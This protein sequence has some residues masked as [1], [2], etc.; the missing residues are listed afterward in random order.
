MHLDQPQPAFAAVDHDDAFDVPTCSYADRDTIAQRRLLD[1][2]A[3]V[4]V[5]EVPRA[6][7]LV[8][9][10]T[11]D[12]P[13]A[14]M[15]DGEQRLVDL[16]RGALERLLDAGVDDRA[17]RAALADLMSPARTVHVHVRDRDG[18]V[19]GAVALFAPDPELPIER[20]RP[21]LRRAAA[22]LSGWLGA[23]VDATPA[24]AL[25]E[26]IPYPALVYEAG[27]VVMANHA[28]ARLCGYGDPGRLIGRGVC[29]MLDGLPPIPFALGEGHLRCRATSRRVR[30]RELSLVVGGRRHAALVLTSVDGG[31]LARASI[32]ASVARVTGELAAVIHACA[33]L[34][35]EVPARAMIAG[36]AAELDGLVRMALLDVATALDDRAAGNHIVVRAYDDGAATI[37]EIVASGRIA[38]G[39]RFG[40]HLG[41]TLCARHAAALDATVAVDATHAQ[42]RS[43]RLS[44]PTVAS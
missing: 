10:R 27:V 35:V 22:A 28:L 17:A 1:G 43:V 21:A 7:A 32:A 29:S 30:A 18:R 6:I 36:D 33:G 12:T 14:V 4:V 38:T 34:T 16:D 31:T 8:V 5:A 37:V 23:D 20:A 24:S 40:E 41:A 25:L 2:L 19:A 13:I 11:G 44:L 3:E 15:T 9:V 42:R 39:S 26:A